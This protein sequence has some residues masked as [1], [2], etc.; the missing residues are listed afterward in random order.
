MSKLLS[1]L[2]ATTLLLSI[3]TYADGLLE[4]QELNLQASQEVAA[5]EMPAL[6]PQEPASTPK[7]SAVRAPFSS[8]TGKVKAKKVRMRLQP[9]LESHVIRELSKSELVSVVDEQGDFW[10]VEPPAGTKAFVFRSFVLDNI[11]EGNRV[12]VRLEPSLDAPIIGH[13]NSG[14]RIQGIISALNNKWL[15]I[16]APA[17]T[18]FYVA[19]EFVEFVGG[20]ELKAQMDK[21]KG[22]VDQLLEASSLLTKAEMMKP[23]EEID[24][25]RVKRSLNG[26]IH[27]YTDFPEA[28]DRAKEQL[29]QAQE[30]YL[31][32]RIGFLETRAGQPGAEENDFAGSELATASDAGHAEMNDRMKL[33]EPI[34]EALY[35]T[36][37][38]LNEERT[39]NDYYDEQ[40]FAA[41]PLTGILEAFTDAVRN[42]PGDY[43]LRDKNGL[44]SAYVYSTQVDLQ[45]YIGK[46]V[47]LLGSERPNNHFAFNA[48]Y[49]LTVEQ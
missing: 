37:S 39:L 45:K 31:Q 21:R 13:L 34:E 2:C 27:E 36:W 14:D 11:I 22:T 10:A 16:A 1:Y 6:P 35:L 26:I 23:F 7:V 17:G 8:F 4:P 24:M 29:V 49:I 47:T 15:E 48:Y 44:P 46:K 25:E 32:K 12:N 40:K 38:H 41:V 18:R 5:P 42:K 19:K 20:P 9:D 30:S 43:V 33:W 3:Q 28:V